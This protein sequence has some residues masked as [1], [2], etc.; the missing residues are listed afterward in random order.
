MPSA[1]C[2]PPPPPRWE[3][4]L[5]SAVLP[6]PPRELMRRTSGSRYSVVPLPMLSGPDPPPVRREMGTMTLWRSCRCSEAILDLN[7]MVDTDGNGMD[8]GFGAIGR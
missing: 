5:P 2:S 3:E 8:A 1:P 6:A 4:V 7:L